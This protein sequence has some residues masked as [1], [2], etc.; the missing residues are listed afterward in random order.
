MVII[1]A[2]GSV[3]RTNGKMN[4]NATKIIIARATSI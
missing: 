3:I 1:D 2:K 4:T